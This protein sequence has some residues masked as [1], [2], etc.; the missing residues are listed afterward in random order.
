[1]IK[2]P[3]SNSEGVECMMAN[4]EGSMLLSARDEKEPFETRESKSS[5]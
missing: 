3:C 5:K 1:M 4:L 2:R